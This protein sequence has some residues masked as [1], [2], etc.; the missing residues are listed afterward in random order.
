MRLLA[1]KD[2]ELCTRLAVLRDSDLDFDTSPYP[3]AWAA[4]HDPSVLLVEHSHPTLEPQLTEGNE[5]LVERAL[6]DI[7]IAVPDQVT[8]QSIRDLFRSRHKKDGIVVPA[9]PPPVARGSSP[10][11]RWS[12]S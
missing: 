6:A 4:D 8:P 9:G 10:R 11:P 3:P 12:A 5:E 2:N 1:T 7:H